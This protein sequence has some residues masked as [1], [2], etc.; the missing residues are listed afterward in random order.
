MQLE[1]IKQIWTQSDHGSLTPLDI[2]RDLLKE[3]SIHKIK[4]LLSEFTL[5]TWLEHIVTT[6]F[7]MLTLRYIVL[8]MHDV[9]FASAGLI[10]A[11]LFAYDVFWSCRHLYSIYTINYNTPV[12]IL[13]RKIGSFLRH[14]NRERRMLIW[15]V[16]VFWVCFLI[17][18]A[19]AFFKVDLFELPVFLLVQFIAAG[20]LGVTVVFTLKSF[21]DKDLEKAHGFLKEIIDFERE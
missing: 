15:M 13:Q 18:C 20:I 11:L 3:V 8:H 5:T 12:A 19:D 7:L 4:G 10:L 1:E 2:K 9:K 6:I 21:R 14:E 16:P 17:V